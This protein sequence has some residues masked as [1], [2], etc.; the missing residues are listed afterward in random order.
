MK[1]GNWFNQ[2]RRVEVSLVEYSKHMLKYAIENTNC[3]EELEPE[4][5]YPFAEHDR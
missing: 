1:K 5:L 4:Y 2:E 3:H